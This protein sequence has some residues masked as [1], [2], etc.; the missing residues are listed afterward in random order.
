[1]FIPRAD[2]D[3]W[4]K[5][6]R[7]SFINSLTGFKPANLI[8]SADLEG[9]T[10]LAIISSVVHLG[11][12]PP[13]FGMVMRPPVVPRHTYENI[14]QTKHFTINHVKDSW[15]EKAHQ[16]SA[17]YDKEESEF[18]SVGLTPAYAPDFKAPY[19]YEASVRMGMEL[20][21]EVPIEE[22]GTVFLISQLVWVD[23]P[24]EFIAEDGYLHLESAGTMAISG[25][26]GYHRTTHRGR[27]SYAKKNQSITVQSDIL[28]GF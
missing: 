1:M 26:D 25:L 6:Y 13:L 16:T 23:V 9:Q 4:D 5:R 27:L 15:F 22:N 17:R 21:R 18:D 19:V 10:N 7:A 28:K 8:G 11:S 2:I 14:I 24:Q 12:N 3:A 20:V